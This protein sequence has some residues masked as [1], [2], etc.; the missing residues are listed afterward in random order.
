MLVSVCRSTS[1]GL[2]LVPVVPFWGISLGWEM[3]FVL[4][5]GGEITCTSQRLYSG[6][7]TKLD[8]SLRLLCDVGVETAEDEGTSCLFFDSGSI[9][10]FEFLFGLSLLF[11]VSMS[12]SISF[13]DLVLWPLCGSA[14][15]GSLLDL[16]SWW[17]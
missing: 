10:A 14:G 3:L 7:A 13:G 11:L 15:T 6:S 16:I 2:W 9:P 5:L 8:L 17:T 4:C 1:D 12:V